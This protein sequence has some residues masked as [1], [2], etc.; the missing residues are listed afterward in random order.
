[1][2]PLRSG[3][4]SGYAATAR[5]VGNSIGMRSAEEIASASVAPRTRFV[6]TPFVMIPPFGV[7]L[8]PDV[9]ANITGSSGPPTG[10]GAGVGII[11]HAHTEGTRG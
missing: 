2:P 1:M 3:R 10:S 11:G 5:E 6:S 7:P 9:N 8:V 4:E